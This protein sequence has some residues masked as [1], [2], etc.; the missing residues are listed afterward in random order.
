MEAFCSWGSSSLSLQLGFLLL[1]PATPAL[2]YSFSATYP[3]MGCGKRNSCCCMFVWR[4]GYRVRFWEL[5]HIEPQSIIFLDP[6]VRYMEPMTVVGGDPVPLDVE[7]EGFRHSIDGILTTVDKLEKQVDEVEQF[8]QSKGNAQVNNSRGSMVLKDKGWEKHATGVKKQQ[9]DPSHREA[10]KRMQELMRQFATILRQISQHK[11]AGPFLQPVDVEG[12]GLHDY[13]E[14]IDKP[15]DFSTIKS[16]ME[17]KDGT[18]YRNVREIYADVRLVFKNAMKY[19]DEKNDIH[20]MA[21]SLLEKF[22]RKW[23]DLLPKVAEEEKRQSQEEAEAQL[24]MQLAQEANYAK[25]AKDLSF[26][27]DKVALHLKNLKNT[28][29]QKC[30]KLSTEEKKVLG[31]AL[32]RLSPENLSRALE[33][34]ADGNPIFQATA[35]EVDLDIDAQSDYTLWRLKIFVKDALEVQAKTA[36]GIIVNSNDNAEDKKNNSKRR[37]AC[38]TLAKTTVKRTKKAILSQ[39]TEEQMSRYESFRRAG[40]Q[41]AN[42]KRLLASITGTQKFSVPMT[43]VVSGIANMFA[44]EL[45][46]TARIVMK[47]RKESGPIRPCHLREA[48]R[49]LK[50]EGKVFKRLGQKLFR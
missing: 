12:L 17:A 28:V 43:I 5:D 11:W 44:G 7:L 29:I 23:L 19:N 39:F 37:E 13:Y 41:K 15:M 1:F 4:E 32:A 31:T 21:K 33:I 30:R 24:D 27:L 22:E 42:M 36:G 38:D 48:Y 35:R 46:E 10:A 45:V 14:V 6:I 8:F 2:L 16:K 3:T 18:G 26:E 40:F 50:L 9:Q 49:R 34:V 20:V 25:L 47:E